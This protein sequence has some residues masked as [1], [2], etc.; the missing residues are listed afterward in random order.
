MKKTGILIV[1]NIFLTT[2]VWAQSEKTVKSDIKS[3]TVF[4]NRAQVSNTAQVYLPA[5]GSTLT[6][7]ELST[8]IDK[9]SIQV[10]AKGS[11]TIM[12]VKHQIN[13]L[14]NQ[15]KA[16][17]IKTL[18]DSLGYYTDRLTQAQA[19]RKVLER[20]EEMI[21][22][23]K[24]I[25]GDGIG[26]SAQKLKEVADYFRNRLTEIQTGYFQTDKTILDLN[27]RIN[28]L[29]AQI[30]EANRDANKPTSEVVV[31]VDA[32]APTTA[33]FELNYIVI[34]AG[35]TPI[36]DLR[37]KDAQSPIQLSYKANVYQN[38]GVDWKDVKVTLS[39][40]N[41]TQS[42]V[43]PELSVWYVNFFNPYNSTARN[44]NRGRYEDAKRTTP[45]ST[46]GEMEKAEDVSV[47]DEEVALT[48]ADK[49]VVSESAFAT[50]FEISVPYTILSDGKPQL[51][52]IK[53]YDVKTTYEYSVVPKMD[54]DAFLM[55]KMTGWEEYNLLSGP[56]NVYFEG[57]FVGETYLDAQNVK[58]T[59][60]IS[61]GRDKKI[62]VKRTKVQDLSSKKFIGSNVKEELGF[63]IN[64]R[65]N[66]REAV[67]ITIE[68]QIPISK[69]AQI[70]V[71]LISAEKAYVNQTTGKVT[72]KL[73]LKANETQ[74]LL[75]KYS[76]K[77]PKSRQISFE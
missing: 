36:Y 11:V 58:D 48:I 40:G 77:Y 75:L 5:G 47:A 34:D 74:K 39:T 50:E 3:V 73:T 25:G 2:S 59:L 43:K 62:V 63:E 51:V 46:A 72:W 65:N 71:E 9:Q 14:K 38:T 67:T 16:K 42:G 15:T 55:A 8:K 64:I 19:Q 68:E 33:T 54:F 32:A 45:S 37:A 52:D 12:A 60:A 66:K 57:T 27:Q 20:E 22:S 26:V 13:Y 21:L 7:E 29:R 30:T 69:D 35:W 44:K 1:L 31:T 41:P 18:E 28:R 53:N 23:N 17:K 49:T 56:A 10:S 70:E 61:L 76:L 24:S 4:L 6:F